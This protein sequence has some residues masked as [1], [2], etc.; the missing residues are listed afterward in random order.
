MG[1]IFDSE[2]KAKRLRGILM[3]FLEPLSSEY[4]PRCAALDASGSVG[5]ARL[6]FE[7]IIYDVVSRIPLAQHQKDN[8][9]E[10][11]LKY[12]RIFNGEYYERVAI[13][14]VV[15]TIYSGWLFDYCKMNLKFYGKFK[16]CCRFSV[17]NSL[18]YRILQPSL[19][20]MCFKNGVVNFDDLTLK[21]FSSEYHC[22]KQYDFNWNP[23]AECPTWKKFLGVPAY[24]GQ[25]VEEIDG[26]LPEYPKR[27]V[28]QKFLGGGFI[29]RKKVKFE[30]LMILYGTGA[31]GKSVIKDVLDGIFGKDEVFPNLQF[32]SLSKEGFDGFNSRR[33]ID[34]C[35]FAYCTEMSPNEFKRPEMV[36]A[37]AS[38]ESMSGRGIGENT[39][40]ITDIPIFI[41][42]S[43]YDWGEVSLIPK[44]S[45]ED[46]SMA[47]RVLLLNFDQKVPEDRRDPELSEKL[48]K[49]KEGIFQWMVSGYRR[50]KRDKWKIKDSI[51]G[52]V[53]HVRHTANRN[54]IP[55]NGKYVHGSIVEYTKFKGISPIMDEEHKHA[56][57]MSTSDIHE[58]YL[59]FCDS[60]Y[61]KSTVGVRKISIDF[62]TM[63]YA[64][65]V[66]FGANNNNGFVMYWNR[67]NEGNAFRWEIPSIV[68]TLNLDAILGEE[69]DE[70]I[71]D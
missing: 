4:T 52:R 57:L 65:K 5:G 29:D 71:N 30:Y 32:S 28:L 18:S 16:E 1:I 9:K 54:D 36:K 55:V 2:L 70:Y 41:C 58:N 39:R 43:N 8:T 38:G 7:R 17:I 63:G 33:V 22:V 40:A 45:P 35:R 42:N 56:V 26:V 49:E 13:S 50:L 64:K 15:D 27:V 47:R 12:C 25:S 68:K 10:E 14:L 60:N 21:P 24:K 51:S 44:D 48:L 66:G 59:K 3:G 67:P 34:G 37:A 53:E 20:V 11:G 19:R 31:N 23:K 6:L 61:L 46:E 62:E 69:E